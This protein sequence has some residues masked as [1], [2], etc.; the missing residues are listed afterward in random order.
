MYLCMCVY[1][2]VLLF[3]LS[4][5]LGFPSGG[6]LESKSLELPKGLMG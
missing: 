6:H 3:S 4:L 2:Y 1:M 5:D